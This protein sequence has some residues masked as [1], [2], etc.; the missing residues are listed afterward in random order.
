MMR[1][2]FTVARCT[3]ARLM[4]GQ[5]LSGVAHGQGRVTTIPDEVRTNH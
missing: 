5:G 4:A 1:K 3:V 2:G